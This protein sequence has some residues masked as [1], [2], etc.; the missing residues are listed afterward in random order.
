MSLLVFTGL[1]ALASQRVR[2]AGAAVPRLLAV[3][4][5][6]CL[7]YIYG[8]VP[9]T[10]A[11]LGTPLAARIV[12]AFVVLAPLG[13]CL[14]MFMPIGL[15]ATIG[16]LGEYPREYVAWGWAV[17][18]FASVV[19]FGAG[20]HPGHDLRLRLGAVPR[21]DLLHRRRGGVDQTVEGCRSRLRCAV[22]Y[23]VSADASSGTGVRRTIS[24]SAR[25]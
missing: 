3:L 13:L 2:R 23:A 22:G 9:L 16:Q 14:G 5:A 17:N 19:G 7:F 4:A 21:A 18:G 25:R 12:I 20:H 6:L 1:G 8:L 15:W 11:L 24:R 10:N